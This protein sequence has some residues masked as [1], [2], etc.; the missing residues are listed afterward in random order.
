M[1]SCLSQIKA[2]PGLV[3][4]WLA[5]RTGDNGGCAAGSNLQEA[6]APDPR[7]L[8]GS[9]NSCAVSLRNLLKCLS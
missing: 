4:S 6:M 8:L 3:L 1:M 5:H 7:V 2:S 9:S